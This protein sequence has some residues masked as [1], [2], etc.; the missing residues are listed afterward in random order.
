MTTEIPRTEA[1]MALAPISSAERLRAVDIARGIALL[2]I[3]FVNIRFFFAP[4]GFAVEP[5]TALDG[6]PRS[7]ADTAA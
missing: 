1:R 4:F 5:T 6:S 7:G 3:L 2:G